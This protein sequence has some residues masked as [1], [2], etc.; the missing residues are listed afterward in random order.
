MIF[1]T[2]S[3]MNKQIRAIFNVRVKWKHNRLL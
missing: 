1:S 3:Q 2:Y